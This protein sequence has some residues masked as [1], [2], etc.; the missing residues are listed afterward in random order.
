MLHEPAHAAASL[1]GSRLELDLAGAV[2]GGQ[3]HLVYQPYID[4]ADGKV[5]GLRDAACAGATRCAAS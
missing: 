4:L 3:M 1:D 2:G 5:V